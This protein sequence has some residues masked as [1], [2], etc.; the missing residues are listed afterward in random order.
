[1]TQSAAPP[2]HVF[3]LL[4]AQSACQLPNCGQRS[5]F[6]E[7]LAAQVGALT[8]DEMLTPLGAVLSLLPV[9][10]S[11]GKHSTAFDPIWDESLDSMWSP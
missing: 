1:M 4:D 2:W 11:I 3:L 7:Y 6:G 10:P 9:D 8:A 5:S